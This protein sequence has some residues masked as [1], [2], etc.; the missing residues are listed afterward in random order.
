MKRLLLA[1]AVSFA[2]AGCNCGLNPVVDC[3]QVDCDAGGS[4]GGG[5]NTGGGGGNNTGGGVG[6]GGDNTGGG[7][8]GGVGGGSGGG[9]GGGSGGGVGG[10]SGGGVGGGSGGG[11]GG[12]SGGGT[13]GAGGG[14]SVTPSNVCLDA[15]QRKCDFWMRCR[16]DQADNQNRNNDQLAASELAKCIAREANDPTCIVAA[17]GWAKGRAG[18]DQ[19]KYNDCLTTAW[20]A[21]TCTRDVVAVGVKC[22]NAPYLTAA[23]NA[24]GACTNDNECINGW[25]NAQGGASI[26]G[27]CQPY[28]NA[29]GGVAACNRDRQCD[30]AKSYCPGGDGNTSAGG[31]ASYLALDAGCN[32]LS[33]QQEECG[34]NHVCASP[35]LFNPGRCIVGKLEGAACTKNLFECNRS[36]RGNAEL[37]CATTAGGDVCVKTQNTTAGQACGTGE[38]NAPF[39]LETEYCAA[40]LCT[41]RRASGQPCTSTDQCVF[42]T[43]CANGP[44]GLQCRPY[45]DTGANCT[46]NGDCKN[47]LSCRGNGATTCQPQ[48]ALDG[49]ACGGAIGVAC[50]GGTFCAAD[51]GCADLQPSGATCTNA[52]QCQSYSCNTTCQTACW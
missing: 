20:P 23:T 38:L 46:A 40:N 43:R 16:T 12:G 51:G 39:C 36:G 3:T 10:G 32:V 17:A 11:T 9:T 37:A 52:N 6:G 8:G 13:G 44:G 7:S 33:Q 4:G 27:T 49:G 35:A 34:P 29:D 15:A 50:A 22:A 47:L 5:D 41:A 19:T 21:A 25:C 31:C 2:L 45:L 1:A 24:G 48:L 42:G 18:F 28:N 26:C 14:G 30:P